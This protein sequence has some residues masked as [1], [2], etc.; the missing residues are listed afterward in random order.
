MARTGDDERFMRLALE[1]ARKGLGRTHP[2][3]AVGA[4]IVK[5]GKLVASGYHARAGTAHAEANALLLAG[6]KARGATIYSTLEPCDHFGRTPPC[7]QAI[8]DSGIKRVVYGSADP[9]PLVDG[10]GVRRMRRAGLEVKGG[11]LEAECDALNEPFLKVMRTG[12]PFVTLKAAMTLDG[13]IATRSGESKWI[14]SEA[15]RRRAHELRDRVD[16]IVVGAG[17]VVADNPRLTTRLPNGRDAM[18]VVID[19]SLRTKPTAKVY[20]PGAPVVVVTSQAT[21]PNRQ[22]RF[23]Q[24]GVQV[25]VVP[26]RSG[27]LELE[28]ALRALA[29]QG[30]L[31]VLVEGGARTTSLFLRA[32]LCDELVLF[33]APTLFGHEGLS[34]SGVLPVGSPKTAPRFEIT[35]VEAIERDLLV[36]A[37]PVR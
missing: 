14:T 21:S 4:V 20:A 6:P 25:L 35:K 17:T 7:T 28:V 32:G 23:S 13:K 30:V 2:N 5:G 24:R 8:L 16:A 18:R 33:L 31:H 9:N 11:V 34:W 27:V 36:R 22:Q 12:L 1:E 26:S 37:R 19:P 15:A 29:K 3:P 10:K